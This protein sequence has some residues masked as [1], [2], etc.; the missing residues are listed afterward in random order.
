MPV[1]D[2]ENEYIIAYHG[3]DYPV[4]TDAEAYPGI[5]I[6]KAGTLDDP[7]QVKPGRQIFCDSKHAWMPILDGIPA[8][9]KAPPPAR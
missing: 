4:I 2:P 5:H 3:I 6:V 9:D 7:S 1:A 8:F